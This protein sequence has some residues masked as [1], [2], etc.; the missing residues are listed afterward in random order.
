ML[1]RFK[2]RTRSNPDLSSGG[3]TRSLIPSGLVCLLLAYRRGFVLLRKTQNPLPELVRG[4][5]TVRSRRFAAV[6]RGLLFVFDSAANTHPMRARGRD[7]TVALWQ[8]G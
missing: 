3:D 5:R 6:R 4:S 8:E 1:L 2:D 7:R